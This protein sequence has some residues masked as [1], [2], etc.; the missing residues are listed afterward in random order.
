MTATEKLLHIRF[1][2]RLSY[3]RDIIPKAM[4]S[5]SDCASIAVSL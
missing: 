2:I 4:V 3:K 5:L 1:L